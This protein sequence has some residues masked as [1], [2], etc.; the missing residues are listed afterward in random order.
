MHRSTWA[1]VITIAILATRLNLGG[2]S[3]GQ[4]TAA[5]QESSPAASPSGIPQLPDKSRDSVV[6][7]EE[8]IDRVLDQTRVVDNSAYER[9]LKGAQALVEV[10]EYYQGST[11]WETID[12]KGRLRDL[13]FFARLSPEKRELLKRAQGLTNQAL[14]ATYGGKAEQAIALARESCEVLSEILGT[15][16][17]S[18]AFCLNTLAEAFRAMGRYDDAEPLFRQ[19]LA[20]SRKVLGEAHPLNGTILNNMALL[21]QL[22]GRFQEAD[23]LYRLA[24]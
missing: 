2:A 10:R 21:G 3:S 9:L 14:S 22:R 15:E 7:L 1:V 18:S 24:L 13:E 5:R 4:T 17:P 8:I 6:T 11:W 12:A 16:H 19:G 23:S 20:L